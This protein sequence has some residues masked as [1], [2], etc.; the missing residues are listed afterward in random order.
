MLLLY[1]G[2]HKDAPS[3][4]FFEKL[5]DCRCSF[6]PMLLI[7]SFD[8]IVVTDLPKDADM[9]LTAVGKQH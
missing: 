1:S 6:S 4:S 5:L 8:V 9:S 7:M 2:S 3:I